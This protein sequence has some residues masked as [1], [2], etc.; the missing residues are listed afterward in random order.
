M[1]SPTTIINH[2]FKEYLVICKILISKLGNK[3]L[4]TLIQILLLYTDTCKHKQTQ[5]ETTSNYIKML[6]WVKYQS[7]MLVDLNFLHYT[8][9]HFP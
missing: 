3:I 5:E 2:I 1:Q 9:L 7:W 4:Y 8:F 6:M